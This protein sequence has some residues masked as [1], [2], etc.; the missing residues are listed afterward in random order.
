MALLPNSEFIFIELI[1]LG[2]ITSKSCLL[3][4]EI[5]SECL[6][7]LLLAGGG[8]W[9]GGGRGRGRTRSRL[10]QGQSGGSGVPPGRGLEA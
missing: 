9:T 1:K 8:A 6:S 2:N 3:T 10:P 5:R 7:G 4:G